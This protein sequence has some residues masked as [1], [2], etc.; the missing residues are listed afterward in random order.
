MNVSM[1]D[2]LTPASVQMT[3]VVVN[4]VPVMLVYPYAQK[5]FTKGIMMGAVKG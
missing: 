5:Y 2:T 4:M 1:E 3:A